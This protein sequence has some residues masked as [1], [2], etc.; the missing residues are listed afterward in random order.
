MMLE[1]Y[2]PSEFTEEC[3]L[4]GCNAAHRLL[5]SEPEKTHRGNLARWLKLS[6][7]NF[8]HDRRVRFGRLRVPNM[9]LPTRIR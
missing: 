2:K 3:S 5:Q 7:H 8:P 4:H 9:D 1:L 6:D